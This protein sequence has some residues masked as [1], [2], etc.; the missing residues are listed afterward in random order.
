MKMMKDLI[1]WKFPTLN[2]ALKYIYFD[3]SY[4]FGLHKYCMYMLEKAKTSAFIFYMPQLIQSLRTN[5]MNQVEKLIL[6]RCKSSNRI[7]HQFLWSLEV[8]EIS[9]Y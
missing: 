5:T 3:Y 7:A 8:E 1:L 2:Y 4:K 9:N 6:K